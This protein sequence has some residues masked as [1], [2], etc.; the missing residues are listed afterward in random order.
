MTAAPLLL[1]ATLSAAASPPGEQATAGVVLGR[2]DDEAD[3]IG[4]RLRCPVCQGM[5]IAESPSE[6][7]QDMMKRVREMLAVGRS[8][9]E[10]TDYFVARYGE[11][12]RLEPTTEGMNLWLWLLPPLAL[13]L[14][15]LTLVLRGRQR[16]RAA[17]PRG[18]TTRSGEDAYV[19]AVRDEVNQ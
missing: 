11:W 19:D 4:R 2:T 12:V 15:V 17:A 3:R 10:I 6:M 14:A 7:A 9:A 13:V 18:P 8:E 1:V 5:P 16:H